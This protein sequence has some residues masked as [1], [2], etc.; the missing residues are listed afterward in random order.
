MSPT[1]GEAGTIGQAPLSLPCCVARS[2][3]GSSALRFS[4]SPLPPGLRIHTSVTSLRNPGAA[5]PSGTTGMGRNLWRNRIAALPR[6]DGVR[7]GFAEST[8]R[9]RRNAIPHTRPASPLG[10]IQNHAHIQHNGARRESSYFPGPSPGNRPQP[11]QR[12]SAHPPPTPALPSKTS[13]KPAQRRAKNSAR[14]PALVSA[15][16]FIISAYFY[17]FAVALTHTGEYNVFHSRHG[18]MCTARP[19]R[20]PRN[21]RHD[22]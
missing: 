9:I 17:I 21:G 11:A 20:D 22:P 14:L 18:A 15:Y 4:V 7:P 1:G 8:S 10:F 12:L 3:M 19:R 2:G 6:S 5:A 13:C 16:I